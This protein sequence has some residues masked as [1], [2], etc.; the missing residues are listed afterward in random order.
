MCVCAFV[1]V[2]DARMRFS[3][4]DNL[5]T[6]CVGNPILDRLLF[7][8]SSDYTANDNIAEVTRGQLLNM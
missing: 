1:R 7:V 5:Y 2:S 3:F 4:L 8:T 6:K